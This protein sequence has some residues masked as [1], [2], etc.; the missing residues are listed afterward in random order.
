MSKL[1]KL[2]SAIKSLGRSK[3]STT[4]LN[5]KADLLTVLV[6]KSRRRYLLSSDLLQHPLIRQLLHRSSSSEDGVLVVSCEVVMFEHLLWMLENSEQ[7]QLAS[8][9]VNE[10]VDFYTY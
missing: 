9:S 4:K 10:L 8:C 6:G 2:T 7:S 3:S 1:A 5:S